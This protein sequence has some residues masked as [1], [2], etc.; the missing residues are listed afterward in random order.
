MLSPA[1]SAGRSS[2]RARS[3]PTVTDAEQLGDLLL[4][5]VA[6]RRG[7]DRPRAGAESALRFAA[8][9]RAS[10]GAPARGDAT[11]AA[12]R[13]PA[14]SGEPYRR[15]ARLGCAELHLTD[16][17]E[18]IAVASIEAV[19]AREILDSRGNPTVEVEVALDD[20]TI[21]RAA[22]PSR[23]LDRRSS[24]RSSCAT[25]ATATAARASTKAVARGARR[26]RPGAGRAS[27]PT[28]QRLVDQALHRP[29]RHAQQVPSSAPTRSS[30]SRSR[31]PEAAADSAGLPLFRYVGGPNAHLLPVPMMNILNGGAH[32]DTNVDIQEFMIAP[33]GAPTF[34]R[35]AAQ[36]AEVY[37]ALKCVLKEPR[38][39][40]RARRR[41]RVRA[42][43]A[44]PTARRST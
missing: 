18:T 3:R 32:A 19:G 11:A 42:R 29:R 44:D 6:R 35:G 25:A 37:H 28:E 31:S 7:G 17:R 2:R 34:A 40:H 1:P 26:D 24:R 21:A 39:G 5:L 10:R 13:T 30:A 33:I 12:H 22:V 36:G 43:P 14:R 9:S 41:G 23:R 15:R 4:A 38:A 16:P 8:T 27:R 20:G